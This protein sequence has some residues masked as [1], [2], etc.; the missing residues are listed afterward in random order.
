MKKS[1]STNNKKENWLFSVKNE[2]GE[3]IEYLLLNSFYNPATGKNYV[4]YTDNKEGDGGNLYVGCYE[5]DE[6]KADLSVKDYFPQELLPV[7]TDE[8]WKWIKEILTMMEMI[9]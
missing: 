3:V 4:V 2:R 9:Q 1:V 5:C 8:E 7:E 6:E